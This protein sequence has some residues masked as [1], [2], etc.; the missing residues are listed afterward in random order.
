MNDRDRLAQLHGL[1]SRLERMPASAERDWMLNEVRA[2][3]VDVETGAKPTALRALPQNEAELAASEPL[4]AEPVAVAPPQPKPVVAAPAPTPRRA[5]RPVPVVTQWTIPAPRARIEPQLA[6]NLLE[7]G[8]VLN[9]DD[10]P[11]ADAPATRPWSRG[12]RA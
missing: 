9:L 10:S 2:R 8:F 5:A 12:L 7:E 4:R 3:A 6:V 1:V 11:S